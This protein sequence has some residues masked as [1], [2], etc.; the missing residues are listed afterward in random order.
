MNFRLVD[1]EEVLALVKLRVKGTTKI[2]LTEKPR[3]RRVDL[4]THSPNITVSHFHLSNFLFFSHCRPSLKAFSLVTSTRNSTI[5]PFHCSQ[6]THLNL[7]NGFVLL[8]EEKWKT[9]LAREI[10][11]AQRWKSRS[12]YIDRI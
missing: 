10:E 6:T 11:T 4:Y 5:V 9:Y 7:H 12:G 1:K 3:E 8:S 2:Y